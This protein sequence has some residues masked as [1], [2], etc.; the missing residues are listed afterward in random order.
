MALLN[1]LGCLA[2]VL[3]LALISIAF[4]AGLLKSIGTKVPNTLERALL[5]A[6]VSFSI[7]QLAVFILLAEG[8]LRRGTL[9]ILFLFMAVSAGSEWKIVP[10]LFHGASEFLAEARKSRF[11]VVLLF[12]VAIVLTL[13]A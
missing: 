1:T 11:R 4:G 2:A 12:A 5:S 7:L 13:D 3:L 6:G 9:G 8:W 10:E